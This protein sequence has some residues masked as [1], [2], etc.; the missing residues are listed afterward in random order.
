MSRRSCKKDMKERGA[1]P[2][3]KFDYYV[4]Y[5]RSKPVF[6]DALVVT[7]EPSWS[8][9]PEPSI[10]APNQ[11]PMAM[12]VGQEHLTRYCLQEKGALGGGRI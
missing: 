4:L 9:T 8:D 6:S 3:G 1:E 10:H 7:P 5:P 12:S 2:S 11:S